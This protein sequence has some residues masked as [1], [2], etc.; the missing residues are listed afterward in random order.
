MKKLLILFFI[1]FTSI[2]LFTSCACKHKNLSQANCTEPEHCLKC[3]EILKSALGHTEGEWIIDKEPTCTENGSKH[4]VCSVCEATV[5]T[6]TLEKLGHIDGKWITDKEPTCTENGSKHQVCSVCKT[7]IKTEVLEK[8]GH[9]EVIDPAVT[10][11]CTQTGLTEGSHCSKCNLIIKKQT[12][13]D[14]ANHNDDAGICTVC[15]TVTDAKLALASY[16]IKNGIKLDSGNRYIIYKKASQNST[17]ITTYIEFDYD[18]LQFIFSMNTDAANGLNTFTSLNLNIG[19]TTQLSE[20]VITS[21]G[22]KFYAKGNIYTQ[23][24]NVQ[25]PSIYNYTCNNNQLYSSMKDLLAANT[26][27]MLISAEQMLQETNIGVTMSMLGFKNL[28]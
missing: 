4:Q 16:I 26:A 21:N 22:Y 27:G 20:M 14:K 3:G 11:T 1:L 7:T 12:N 18:N 23:T 24:F 9:T 25:N 5:K 17:N 15:N 6:E 13:I 28:Y 19:D 8:L 2:L 10:P